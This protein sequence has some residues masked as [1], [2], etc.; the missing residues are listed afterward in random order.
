MLREWVGCAVSDII[1]LYSLNPQI[2]AGT[3]SIGPDFKS[4]S[5]MDRFSSE[6][7]EDFSMAY[8]SLATRIVGHLTRCLDRWSDQAI[9]DG[10]SDIS[11][12]VLRY[13]IGMTLVNIKAIE[14]YPDSPFSK[15]EPR[16]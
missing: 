14:P 2:L 4:Y 3:L 8:K 13:R 5:E 7:M 10:F 16:Y 1:E 9:A 11:V 6:Q 12:T 15:Y